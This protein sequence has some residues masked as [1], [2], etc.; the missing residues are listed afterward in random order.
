VEEE[1]VDDEM[2]V[3]RVD[4]VEKKLDVVSREMEWSKVWRE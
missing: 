3:V 4:C 2:S 1:F